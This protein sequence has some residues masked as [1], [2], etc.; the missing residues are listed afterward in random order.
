MRELSD[1]DQ[2]I[3]DITNICNQISN[4]RQCQERVRCQIIRVTNNQIEA[5]NIILVNQP[6][7]NWSECQWFETIID[8][9]C[10]RRIYSIVFPYILYSTDDQL[11][12]LD[13]ILKLKKENK[14][15]QIQE[16]RIVYADETNFALEKEKFLSEL[17]QQLK[18]NDDRTN[19]NTRF[20]DHVAHG[21]KIFDGKNR[22]H[23][24][25]NP[26]HNLGESWS[27]VAS[28]VN[29]IQNEQNPIY[30]YEFGDAMLV[31]KQGNILMEKADAIIVDV[32]N[33]NPTQP[34]QMVYEQAGTTYKQACAAL[35]PTDE[36]YIMPGG[37]LHARYIIHMSLPCCTPAQSS[38][39]NYLGILRDS[40]APVFK[41]ASKF[42]INRI[43]LLPDGRIKHNYRPESLLEQLYK[44]YSN[45]N[46]YIRDIVMVIDDTSRFSAWNDTC[47]RFSAQCSIR[48]AKES[49]AHVNERPSIGDP[50]PG[51]PVRHSADDENFNKDNQYKRT[52]SSM[53]QET[54]NNRHIMSHTGDSSHSS[55]TRMLPTDIIKYALSSCTVLIVKRGDISMEHTDVI[56]NA[57]N[58]YLNDGIGV[59]G[60]IYKG[61]GSVYADACKKCPTING[62]GWRLEPGQAIALPSGD[63][64]SHCVIATVG[65]V[66]DEKDEASSRKKLFSCYKECLSLAAQ[67]N[68]RSIAFPALSCGVYGYPIQKA[69]HI[70][71]EAVQKFSSNLR[72]IVFVLWDEHVF[73]AWIQAIESNKCLKRLPG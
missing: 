10:Q 28:N 47:K 7:I 68:Y 46:T 49:L 24:N 41:N 65:P 42:R 17:K 57:A 1:N 39:Q 43:A 33:S 59:T 72:E 27:F 69:A 40:F 18:N 52:M 53:P 64:L 62:K 25:N 54:V 51:R 6:G 36:L 60:A 19:E 70:A 31:I 48:R 14:L 22:G 66:F 32:D 23:E 63:L 35:N 8:V 38:S 45:C 71:I 15:Q 73:S 37:D 34:V 20:N 56:V 30:Q 4:D 61:A 13:I 11:C 44:V 16:I 26:S 55:N 21:Y 3:C 29:N 67:K 12:T 50:V 9:A 58:E 5:E 2:L